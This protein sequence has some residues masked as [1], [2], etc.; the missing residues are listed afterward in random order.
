MNRGAWQATVRGVAKNQT[1]LSDFTYLLYLWDN[2]KSVGVTAIPLYQN[3]LLT[4]CS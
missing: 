2:D 3:T 4:S 1:R